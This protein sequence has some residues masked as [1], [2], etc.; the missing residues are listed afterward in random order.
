MALRLRD[1]GRHKPLALAV[2]DRAIRDLDDV[3]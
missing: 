1:S 3:G 2:E